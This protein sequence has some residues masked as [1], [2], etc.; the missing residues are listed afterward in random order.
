M[1]DAAGRPLRQGAV[2]IST[3]SGFEETL[4]LTGERF[5]LAV[6]STGG[7]SEFQVEVSDLT[8]TST[9]LWEQFNWSWQPQ[10]AH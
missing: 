3:Q 1:K 4:T 8:N 6:P 5:S 10:E 7:M 2:R 9:V